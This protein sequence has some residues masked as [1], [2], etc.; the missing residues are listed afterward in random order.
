MTFRNNYNVIFTVIIVDLIVSDNQALRWANFM[1]FQTWEVIIH[2]ERKYG[3]LFYRQQLLFL[4]DKVL[5]VI[6][7]L[8]KM[9][10]LN[11]V[12]I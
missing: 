6:S 11:E 7:T 10:Y 1:I 9:E 4:S 3:N 5:S 12:K 8:V 2:L